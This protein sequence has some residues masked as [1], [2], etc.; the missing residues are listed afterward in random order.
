MIILAPRQ[1]FSEP[2]AEKGP[3]WSYR[4][5]ILMVWACAWARSTQG[6]VATP[7]AVR[8]AVPRNVRRETRDISVVLHAEGVAGSPARTRGAG[9]SGPAAAAAD[10]TG[11]RAG[12]NPH[13][14]RSPGAGVVR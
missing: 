9:L 10:Y 6:P 4:I 1:Q 12:V 3:V 13:A 2:A 14:K 5:P 7:A 11:C 8:P